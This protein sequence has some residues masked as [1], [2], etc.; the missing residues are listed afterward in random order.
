MVHLELIGNEDRQ[1]SRAR[2]N[3]IQLYNRCCCCC[4]CYVEFLC[5]ARPFQTRQRLRPRPPLASPRHA[6]VGSVQPLSA[7]LAWEVDGLQTGRSADRPS[8]SQSISQY[9]LAV[10]KDCTPNRHC[11]RQDRQTDR[12]AVSPRLYPPIKTRHMNQ[13]SK[14]NE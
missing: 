1:I 12:Q 7:R 5:V 11:N 10:S 9:L 3:H 13:N 4:C 8:I 2:R 14:N 6:E